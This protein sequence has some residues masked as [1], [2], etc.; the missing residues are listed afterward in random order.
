[1]T[2]LNEIRNGFKYSDYKVYYSYQTLSRYKL[3]NHFTTH[4][5]CCIIDFL[6][7][8][9]KSNLIPN[10]RNRYTCKDTICNF[11]LKVYLYETDSD[12][13]TRSS[14]MYGPT[15][16]FNSQ[17]ENIVCVLYFKKD[18]HL[19]LLLSQTNEQSQIILTTNKHQETMENLEEKIDESILE[20]PIY[21]ATHIEEFKYV[22]ETNNLDIKPKIYNFDDDILEK[23][24]KE[25]KKEF[26]IMS[27]SKKP[28]RTTLIDPNETETEIEKI[29]IGNNEYLSQK[30]R[31]KLLNEMSNEELINKKIK[32]QQELVKKLEKELVKLNNNIKSKEE[33][34]IELE[35]EIKQK[36]LNSNDIYEIYEKEMKNLGKLLEQQFAIKN[37]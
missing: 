19:E 6:K 3:E 32:K 24:E 33:N 26:M 2:L 21:T 1:M 37:T 23:R 8:I 35:N 28:E 27:L 11:N 36:I 14:Y 9:K 30:G 13:K 15:C 29:E 7:Y 10:Y 18:K 4:L 16:M 12:S 20:F 31:E 17:G 22:S 25:P 5:H 34:Y